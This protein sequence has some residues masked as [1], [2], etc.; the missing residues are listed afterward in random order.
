ML[1]SQR[2]AQTGTLSRGLGR[3]AT[4]RASPNPL[5][6][7]LHLSKPCELSS[8]PPWRLRTVVW[9]GVRRGQGSVTWRRGGGRRGSLWEINAHPGLQG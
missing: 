2:G 8:P 4:S 7:N 6:Q 9:K 3:S 5:N 1:F